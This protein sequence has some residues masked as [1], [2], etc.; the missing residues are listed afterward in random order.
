VRLSHDQSNRPS[1]VGLPAG[2]REMEIHDYLRLIRRRWWLVILV[3]AVA[4]G[5]VLWTHTD[6]PSRYS[7]TATVTA[8]SL[9]GH[10][11]SPYVGANSTAQFAADFEA[12]ATQQPILNAVS[13]ALQVPTERIRDGLI[14]T[15]VST[16][17][18]MSALIDVEYVTTDR[19]QAG[20]VA[21]AVAMETLRALFEPALPKTV[22]KKP[23][24]EGSTGTLDELLQQPQTITLYPTINESTTQSVIREV[25]VAAGAGLF[26]AVFIVIIADVLGPRRRELRDSRTAADDET[27]PHEVSSTVPRAP[28]SGAR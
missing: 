19:D 14:V 2:S 12:T 7:A 18:G 16:T 5:I 1:R 25:Q 9:I 4:A 21:E 26:F 8:R 23:I 27:A 6:D 15:P 24:G 17:A 28:A 11:R 10:I 20:L 22:T 3:P 13:A